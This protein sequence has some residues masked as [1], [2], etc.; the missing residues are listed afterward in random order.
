VAQ[1]TA[2]DRPVD[3]RYG[4]A[5]RAMPK[6]CPISR[7]ARWGRLPVPRGTTLHDGQERDRTADLAVFSRVPLIGSVRHDSSESPSPDQQGSR[8]RDTGLCGSVGQNVGRIA[9]TAQRVPRQLWKHGAAVEPGDQAA[10][11]G[12]PLA[13]SASRVRWWSRISIGGRWST[14]RRPRI[15]VLSLGVLGVAA[16]VD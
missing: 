16:E 5:D 7:K 10:L 1:L 13:R 14:V 9:P 3:S 8:R 2:T 11:T 6:G 12:R 4:N 15:R